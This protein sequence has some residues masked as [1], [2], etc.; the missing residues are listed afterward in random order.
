MK[1]SWG[2]MY[3]PNISDRGGGTM[4]EGDCSGMEEK[5]DPYLFPYRCR[6]IAT[7]WLA[8]KVISLTTHI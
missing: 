6:K 3:H 5:E 8:C 1:K 7:R 4:L 2:K